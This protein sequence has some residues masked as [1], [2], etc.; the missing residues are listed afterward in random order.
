ME[1]NIHINSK[2][3]ADKSNELKKFGVYPIKKMKSVDFTFNLSKEA[4]RQPDAIEDVL[5]SSG[6]DSGIVRKILEEIR[7][8]DEPNDDIHY[9]MIMFSISNIIQ[10]SMSQM[11]E[12]MEVSRRQ[13]EEK[14]GILLEARESQFITNASIVDERSSIQQTLEKPTRRFNW[15]CCM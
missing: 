7:R 11:I 5:R 4:C 13:S 3:E 14:L 12:T 6:C 2:V 9:D 10:K 1:I 8:I 15:C